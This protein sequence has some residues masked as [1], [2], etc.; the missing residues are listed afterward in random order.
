MNRIGAQPDLHCT[1]VSVV[2]AT[3]K[4]KMAFPHLDRQPTPAELANFEAVYLLR[5]AAAEPGTVLWEITNPA[6]GEVKFTALP[7]QIAR[8]RRAAADIGIR[9][10]PES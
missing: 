1:E 6:T 9:C 3:G 10:I 2:F 8:L 5:E 4:V 7:A